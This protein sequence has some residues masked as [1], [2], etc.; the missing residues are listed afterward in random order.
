MAILRN[1]ELHFVRCNPTR[2]N[3]TF[4]KENPAWEVQIRTTS[5]EQKKEWLELNLPVKT[6]DPDEGELFYRVQLKK[7]SR[8][9]DG[10]LS[11]A[12][13][14]VDGEKKP[15]DPD[16]VGN[17]SIG[18]V[19]I[20]Q[21]EYTKKDGSHGVAALLMAIQVTTLRE[22]VRKPRDREDFEETGMV[23]I[24]SPEADDVVPF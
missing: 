18:N 11:E 23:R 17:G 19:R 8:K 24:P 1:C 20:W 3:N 6:V 14:V 13:E 12:P 4:D 10:S 16:I 21:Y 7:G 9:K 15:L 5:K 2:P 22:Y